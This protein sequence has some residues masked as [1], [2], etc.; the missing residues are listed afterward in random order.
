MSDPVSVDEAVFD[1]FKIIKRESKGSTTIENWSDWLRF[2]HSV[3]GGLNT[4]L[5]IEA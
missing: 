3:P 4:Q 2:N 1:L 5:V